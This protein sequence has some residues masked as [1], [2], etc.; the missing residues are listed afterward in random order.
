MIVDTA[1]VFVPDCVAAQLAGPLRRL[2]TDARRVDGIAPASEI[3]DLVVEFE[4]VAMRVERRRDRIDE[5]CADATPVDD[6][7]CSR[8]SSDVMDTTTAAELIG[9]STAN[10]TARARSGALRGRQIGSTWVFDRADVEA[11]R[12]RENT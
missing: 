1:G 10:V 8:G 6:G 5:G 7:S 12:D 9:C 4:L 3:M 11:Y 2:V